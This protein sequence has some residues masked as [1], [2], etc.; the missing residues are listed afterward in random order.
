MIADP[1]AGFCRAILKIL[2]KKL[3]GHLFLA[4]GFI[5]LWGLSSRSWLAGLGDWI[6]EHESILRGST[7]ALLLCVPV[8]AFP[9]MV[10]LW[11]D[12]AIVHCIAGALGG[13][14]TYSEWGYASPALRRG[15]MFGS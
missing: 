12:P 5:A 4:V 9:S 11:V 15:I 8:W 14:G 2:V 1:R 10:I 6:P 7:F 13:D 3:I